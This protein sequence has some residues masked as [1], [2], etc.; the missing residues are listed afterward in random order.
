MS[1][2]PTQQI[3]AWIA[4]FTSPNYLNYVYRCLSE[5]ESER[6]V[7][8][9][10]SKAPNPAQE[11]AATASGHSR[12]KPHLPELFKPDGGVSHY[13][14]EIAFQRQNQYRNRYRDV[15]P[16]DR[17][18]VVVDVKRRRSLDGKARNVEGKYLN[19]NWVLELFG[20]KWWIAT[21]APLPYTAHTFLSL[22]LQPVSPPLPS[23][24]PSSPTQTRATRIR[25]IVQLTMNIEHGRRKA[26]AYFPM[27]IGESQVLS[28]DEEDV[29]SSIKV[30]VLDIQSIEEAHCIKST[31]RIVPVTPV[32][33]AYE[34]DANRGKHEDV[35]LEHT[36]E[37]VT[38]QHMLYTSWPDHGVPEVDDR[39]NLLAFLR[40]VDSTN[41][42]PSQLHSDNA[43][44]LDP[45]P[46][47]IVGCSA[48][49]GRTGTFI[50]LSSLLRSFGL[51]PPAH[52]PSPSSVLP[53]SP[54]GPLPHALKEDLVVQEVD[55]LRE[56]R[57]RMVERDE[58]LL[59]I[60]EILASAL[61][62]AH[63]Q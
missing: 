20:H 40:L 26:H 4:S 12:G 42:D 44:T 39:S 24:S 17:T 51:L 33:T 57:P 47:I 25:T 45:D 30:T 31:L 7:A 63:N 2:A 27:D 14:V 54:L 18:R 36:P 22:L 23:T 28:S 50:A 6:Q 49:I 1:S 5:R 56:Q 9:Y 41:R 3:P 37:A 35:Y 52:T 61:H 48:G 62:T 58:Q 43:I 13:S 59:L 32:R 38:V 34:D 8:R 10:L 53:A 29:A 19:A 11:A 55:S 15:E 60:Y 21:Q 46:P 16:Y